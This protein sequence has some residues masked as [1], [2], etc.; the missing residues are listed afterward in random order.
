MSKNNFFFFENGEYLYFAIYLD[1][2]IQAQLTEG[3]DIFMD[4]LFTSFPLLDRLSKMRIGG[5]GTVR[6]NRL[7]RVSIMGKKEMEK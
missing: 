2:Y 4:N 1:F 6:Q 3:S 7:Y 5:T